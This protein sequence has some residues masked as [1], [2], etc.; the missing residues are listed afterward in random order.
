MEKRIPKEAEAIIKAL[1]PKEEPN[2]PDSLKSKP[3]AIREAIKEGF[4]L[5]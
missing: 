3:D 2:M 4:G 5:K 1:M